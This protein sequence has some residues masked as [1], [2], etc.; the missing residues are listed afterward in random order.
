M[1]RRVSILAAVLVFAVFT[2]FM[3]VQAQGATVTEVTHSPSVPKA[4]EDIEITL[5]FDDA[6]TI[7]VT[8]MIYCT[9]EPVFLCELPVDMTE[10]GNMFTYTITKDYEAGTLMGFKFRVAY[11]N[12]SFQRIPASLDDS[13]IHPVKGPYEGFYYFTFSLESEQFPLYLVAILIIIVV[14][15]GIAAVVLLKKKRK[16]NEDEDE[17]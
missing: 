8:S 12:G 4:G 11:E 2:S 14:V 10:D 3:P 15:V 13:D 9:I 7:N 16:G 1:S 17:D 6:S 5:E